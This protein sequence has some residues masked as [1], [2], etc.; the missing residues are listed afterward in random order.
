MS[1]CAEWRGG[2]IGTQTAIAG[3]VGKRRSPE[4]HWCYRFPTTIACVVVGIFLLD[5]GVAF[6]VCSDPPMPH[7][8]WQ[9][10]SMDGLDLSNVD[11]SEGRLRDTSFL[12]TD[13][14][15]SI[16]RKVN[17]FRA[18]FVSSKLRSADLRDADLREA[19]FTKADMEN[20]DLRNADLQRARLY[21][22]SLRG[23]NLSGANLRGA[24]LTYVDLSEAL[25][26]DGKGRCMQNSLGRCLFAR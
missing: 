23:A 7:V 2:R 14:S 26:I 24:D 9:R 18:K 25:W 4:R 3:D 19:D 20:A 5:V 13:L 22:T 12:R 11:I 15:G 8:N 21:R 10:C 17:G 6:A 16:L 1:D